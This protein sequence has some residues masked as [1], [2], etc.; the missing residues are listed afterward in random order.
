MVDNRRQHEFGHAL[1]MDFDMLWSWIWT[2]FGHGSGHALDMD[3]DILY[4]WIWTCFGHGFGH[5]FGHVLGHAL[6]LKPRKLK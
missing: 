4:S 2:N 5:A 6:D 3:L 1:V